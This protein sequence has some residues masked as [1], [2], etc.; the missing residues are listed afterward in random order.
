MVQNES[1]FIRQEQRRS[2][3][4]STT[5]ERAE[6]EFIQSHALKVV[7]RDER[8]QAH[9]SKMLLADQTFEF[10]ENSEA[11]AVEQA[12]RLQATFER[13]PDA[14]M[15]NI[16][17]GTNNLEQMRDNI[18]GYQKGFA[19]NDLTDTGA[20]IDRNALIRKKNKTQFDMEK[21]EFWRD[22][23]SYQTFLLKEIS[24]GAVTPEEYDRLTKLLPTA[25]MSDIE[26]DRNMR[27]LHREMNNRLQLRARA[28]VFQGQKD[29]TQL[30]TGGG[31]LPDPQFGEFGGAALTEGVELPEGARVIN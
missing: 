11:R 21:L 18:T 26:V 12:E 4:F 30:F 8:A 22:I 2:D 25:Q 7:E 20:W 27:T 10:A 31:T 15:Q 17:D 23:D 28:A 1:Q 14:E 5:D 24:G 9:I 16:I 6:S 3:E 19:W 13:I 29:P